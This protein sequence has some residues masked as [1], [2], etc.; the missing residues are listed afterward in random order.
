VV[1]VE[2]HHVRWWPT[3]RFYMDTTQRAI[4]QYVKPGMYPHHY[5]SPDATGKSTR[6]ALP[7][8]RVGVTRTCS[9]G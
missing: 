6:W 7:L 8:S 5:N 1:N 3:F 9:W 4:W 2:S